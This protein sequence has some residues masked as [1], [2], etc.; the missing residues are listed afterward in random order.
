MS[1]QARQGIIDLLLEKIKAN[2]GISR[3]TLIGC[4]ARETD[5]QRRTFIDFI[6]LLKAS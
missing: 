3:F 6:K 2:P 1:V 5:L 4:F